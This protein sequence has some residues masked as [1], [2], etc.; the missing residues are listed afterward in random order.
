MII[1]SFA[2]NT[3]LNSLTNLWLQRFSL[4]VIWNI[5]MWCLTLTPLC[6]TLGQTVKAIFETALVVASQQAN[7]RGEG[8]GRGGKGQVINEM[9]VA[10]RRHECGTHIDF[11]TFFYFRAEG[12]WMSIRR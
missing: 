6:K 4:Q 10:N 12:L 3:Q 2:P 5:G 8:L 11:K 1:S 7:G 9:Q